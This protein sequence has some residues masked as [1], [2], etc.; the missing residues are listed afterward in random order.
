MIIDADTHLSPGSA[1]FS[2]QTHIDNARNA[3]IDTCLCCLSPHHYTDATGLEAGNRYVYEAQ[4]SNPDEIIGFGW[5]DPTLGLAKAKDLATQCIEEFCFPGVKMNG[6]QN[7]YYIDDPEIGIPLAEHIVRLGGMLAFHIGPDAYEKTHPLRAEKIARRFPETTVLMV[8]MGMTDPG[9]TEATLR[10]AKECSGMHLV[11]SQT[12]EKQLLRAVQELGA[13]RV[14][15]G[16]DFPFR[17]MKVIRSMYEHGLGVEIN[18]GELD[19][20]MHGN[21]SR[22][23]EL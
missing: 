3:G 18:K 16:T 2:L 12:S 7:D 10:S 9:M 8:H 1:K 13:D 22:L 17:N 20:I 15:F 6:A 19:L 4:K 23:F 14:L 11:G 5:A 21:A